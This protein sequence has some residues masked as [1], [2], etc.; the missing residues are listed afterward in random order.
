MQ[1][2]KLENP[3][4]TLNSILK[5]TKHQFLKGCITY[6]EYVCTVFQQWFTFLSKY[7]NRFVT[8]NYLVKF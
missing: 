4:G 3:G 5:G 2:Y 8:K 1:W 7:S 6:E